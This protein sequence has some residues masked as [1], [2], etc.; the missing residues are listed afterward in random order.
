MERLIDNGYV[1]FIDG[2]KV[3]LGPMS[4]KEAEVLLAR[5]NGGKELFRLRTGIYINPVYIKKLYLGD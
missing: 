3:G 1:E 2:E 5:L 4:E